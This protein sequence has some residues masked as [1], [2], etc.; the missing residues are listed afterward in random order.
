M[1]SVYICVCVS[2]CVCWG[3]GG[4]CARAHMWSSESHWPESVLFS[5]L[6]SRGGTVVVRFDS[7]AITRWYILLSTLF[8]YPLVVLG[9][10]HA[11]KALYHWVLPPT[12]SW[13][14]MTQKM[15]SFLCLK[16]LKRKNSPKLMFVFLFQMILGI[17]RGKAWMFSPYLLCSCAMYSHLLLCPLGSLSK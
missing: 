5:T 3:G 6:S 13:K 8:L 2:V 9:L 1:C 10:K 16:P 4:M 17:V 15:T 7:K 14:A 11:R 12:L